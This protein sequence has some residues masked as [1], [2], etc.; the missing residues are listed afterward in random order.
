MCGCDLHS[1]S[2]PFF[3]KLA[4]LGKGVTDKG[5]GALANSGCGKKLTSLHLEGLILL[6]SCDCDVM[7]CCS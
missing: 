4:V 5:V 2:P 3:C 7:S 6:F 1:S